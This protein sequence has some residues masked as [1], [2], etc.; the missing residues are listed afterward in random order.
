MSTFSITT[1]QLQ[2][3]PQNGCCMSH[4]DGRQDPPPT[5][6]REASEKKALEK[7]EPA[8]DPTRLSRTQT[9]FP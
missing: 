1:Y 3:F 5:V 8:G 2:R 7:Q 9:I 4:Q 6:T